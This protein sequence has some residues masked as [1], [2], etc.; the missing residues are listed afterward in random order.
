M[1]HL[2]PSDVP[3]FYFRISRL[4]RFSSAFSI[5]PFQARC[6]IHPLCPP[7]FHERPPTLRNFILLHGLCDLLSQDI[8]HFF[9]QIFLTKPKY[10][11]SLKGDR[12][13]QNVKCKLQHVT[14]VYSS[15]NL[16]KRSLH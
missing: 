11:F 1:C 7:S 13:G 3:S 10:N 14:Q 4:S 8:S 2:Y 15:F 6:A 5:L 9:L 16:K 12:D